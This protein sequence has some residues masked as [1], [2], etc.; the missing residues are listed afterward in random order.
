MY[1]F[2]SQEHLNTSHACNKHEEY[3]DEEEYLHA[4]H[5]NSKVK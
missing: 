1:V 3:D 4:V 2:I 5:P